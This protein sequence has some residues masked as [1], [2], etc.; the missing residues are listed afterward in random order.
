M[1]T[2]Y[3]SWAD[4]N[5]SIYLIGN[6]YVWWA[7][8]VSV[9]LTVLGLVFGAL[10][11]Q[12]GY[13]DYKDRQLIFF[14][15]PTNYPT[16]LLFPSSATLSSILPTLLTFLLGY[17]VHYFPYF[18]QKRQL[19]IHHYLPALYFSILILSVLFELTTRR[20]PERWRLHLAGALLGVTI[21]GWNKFSPMTYG[22]EWTSREC[23]RAKWREGWD[24]AW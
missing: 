13:K 6:P 16:P 23:E 1:L 14:K 21:F 20:L 19:F 17:F 22:G 10:R 7:G 24:F 4:S 2:I 5:R 15:R 18:T 11:W 3:H 8:T 12:R 9:L